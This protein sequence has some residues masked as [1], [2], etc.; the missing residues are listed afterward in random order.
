MDY[1]IGE[2]GEHI[3]GFGEVMG[4]RVEDVEEKGRESGED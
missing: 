4:E 3:E 2:P 1:A